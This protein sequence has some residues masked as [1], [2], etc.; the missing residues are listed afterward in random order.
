MSSL[1]GDFP[2]AGARGSRVRVVVFVSVSAAWAKDNRT[3]SLG[4]GGVY[5]Q[6]HT[7]VALSGLLTVPL[8]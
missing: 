3:H 5:L 1:G 8:T 7:T 2:R 4:D 6:D